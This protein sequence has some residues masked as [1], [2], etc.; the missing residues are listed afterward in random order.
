MKA[1]VR[2]T[3]T[4]ESAISSRAELFA[5][6][7]VAVLG[8]S[9]CPKDNVLRELPPAVDRQV[10]DKGD[11]ML[12]KA[13]LANSA[14]PF[15]V[16]A[17]F[18]SPVFPNQSE[19]LAD[20]GIPPVETAGNSALLVATASELSALIASPAVTRIRYLGTQDSLARLHPEFEMTCLRSFEEGTQSK[21]VDLT[22]RF[23]SPPGEKE[24]AAVAA[25]RYSVVTPAGTNWVVRGALADFPLLLR[26]HEIIYFETASKTRGMH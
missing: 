26:I 13:L 11:E 17:R 23:G 16:I 7:A 21:T 25:A 10:T 5:I 2:S 18:T 22:I 4:Y 9:G 8:L 14:M 19:L 20:A 1:A 6:L 15:A 3:A 24:A 12:R